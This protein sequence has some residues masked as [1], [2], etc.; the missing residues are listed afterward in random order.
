MMAS[1]FLMATGMV[2]MA[3]W[4]TII[5]GTA[6]MITTGITIAI[7]GKVRC[8]QGQT[9]KFDRLPGPFFDPNF[10]TREACNHAP[11]Q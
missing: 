10:R 11:I 6:T 8:S 2:T 9:T 4:P 5:A 3:K 7:T 1:G